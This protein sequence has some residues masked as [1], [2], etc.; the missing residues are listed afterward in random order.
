MNVRGR[1]GL[2]GG[3]TLLERS[4]SRG[5]AVRPQASPAGSLAWCSL[6][7]FCGGP[8]G[9]HNLSFPWMQQGTRLQLDALPTT[10]LFSPLPCSECILQ[11]HLLGTASPW[12]SVGVG[13]EGAFRP[14]GLHP[15]EQ[16]GAIW[17]GLLRGA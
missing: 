6:S 11:V 10:L 9:A 12:N 13:L 16:T 4:G 1:R 2:R 14:Y 8:R 15:Q 5:W 7:S 3:R 17:K